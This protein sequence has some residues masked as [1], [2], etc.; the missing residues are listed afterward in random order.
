MGERLQRVLQCRFRDELLN[1]ETF[2][3]LK[4]AQILIEQWRIHYN[5]QRPH[6]ALAYRPPAPV[7]RI[8]KP[9]PTNQITTM[10]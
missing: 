5:T 2:Y 4:E 3:S 8:T 7:T 9:K 1:G 6:Y 10:Q